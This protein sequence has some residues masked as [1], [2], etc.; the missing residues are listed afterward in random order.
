MVLMV[1][2]PPASAGDAGSMPE[3]G[4][5]PG[6]GNGNS[7]QYSCLRN[8]MDRGASGLQSMG[9]EKSLTQLSNYTAYMHGGFTEKK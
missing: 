5:S 2:D 1:K 4:S 7:L 3:L 8:P 9:L 6:V